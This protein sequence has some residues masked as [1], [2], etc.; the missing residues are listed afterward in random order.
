[1]VIS[2]S[3]FINPK[4]RPPQCSSEAK[5][6]IYRG[7]P[8]S[9]SSPHVFAF[10]LLLPPLYKCRPPS[11]NRPF[12][13]KQTQSPQS[14]NQRNLLCH[15]DLPQHSAPSDSKKQ[16]Q[17]KPIPRAQD[18]I[19]HPTYERT[20]PI[21]KTPKSTQPLFCK[22]FTTIFRSAQ[23]EKTNPNK[24]NPS[25]AQATNLAQVHPQ[26]PARPPSSVFC[27]PASVPCSRSYLPVRQ[28][29]IARECDII[30]PLKNPVLQRQHI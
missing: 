22:G 13:G 8:A 1:M 28:L 6:P 30:S 16:T 21:P 2:K 25:L 29:P 14:P 4:G 27:R 23:R 3:S 15:K 18:D 26:P 7:Q 17:T 11:T 19:R 24:A 5:V 9:K 10:C 20:N 12:Y